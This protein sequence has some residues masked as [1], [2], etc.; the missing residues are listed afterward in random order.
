VWLP[1]VGDEVFDIR[2][3]D[4]SNR[5]I[6]E[7]LDDRFEPVLDRLAN[8]E[9]LRKH[10]SLFVD[11]C[12]LSERQRSRLALRLCTTFLERTGTDGLLE[13]VEDGFSLRLRRDLA[14]RPLLEADAYLTE[15]SPPR[16]LAAIARTAFV[17]T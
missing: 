10:V 2:C 8:R 16:V 17:F 4:L 11:A 7:V 6:A 15:P 9:P 5:A 1:Q 13:L 3:S 14:I 12:E